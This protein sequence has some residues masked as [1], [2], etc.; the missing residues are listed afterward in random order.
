MEFRFPFKT[1][2]VSSLF[3]FSHPIQK[4]HLRLAGRSGTAVDVRSMEGLDRQPR[5]RHQRA[6][7]VATQHCGSIGKTHTARNGWRCPGGQAVGCGSRGA[8]ARHDGG[9]H[10]LERHTGGARAHRQMNSV[11]HSPLV[12]A[13]AGSA[14]RHTEGGSGRLRG[15]QLPTF[16]WVVHL[17]FSQEVGRPLGVIGVS[18][19]HAGAG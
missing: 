19:C 13:P 15:R 11:P 5:P 9:S 12:Y 10:A 1:C 16:T 4:W 6:H 7:V 3:P 2:G 8:A 18:S 14:E 17:S